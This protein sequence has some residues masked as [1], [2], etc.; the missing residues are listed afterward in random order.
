MNISNSSGFRVVGSTSNNVGRDQINQVISITTQSVDLRGTVA[1]VIN[2]PTNSEDEEYDEFET[3]KRGDMLIV[4]TIL[5]EKFREWEWD[6]TLFDMKKA[7]DVERRV[8]IARIQ[9]KPAST[10]IVM[11]YRGQGSSAVKFLIFSRYNYT[12]SNVSVAQAWKRDFLK[13]SQEIDETRLQLFGIN[14]SSIPS[15]I[16]YDAG[17]MPVRHFIRESEFWG[18]LFLEF[19]K[20]V[21]LRES[22]V[23]LDP[24]LNCW[25]DTRTAMLCND[26]TRAHT[27]HIFGEL[28]FQ[29]NLDP[30]ILVPSG[31]DMLKQDTAIRFF[32]KQGF[33]FDRAIVQY[34]YAIRN[35]DTIEC[36]C[37]IGSEWW[38]PPTCLFGPLR[39]DAIYTRSGV[40]IAR[41]PYTCESDIGLWKAPVRSQT[42]IHDTRLTR[43]VLDPPKWGV[44]TVSFEPSQSYKK[45]FQE[46]WLA[47]APRVFNATSTN[48]EDY[49]MIFSEWSVEFQSPYNFNPLAMK[50]ERIIYLFMH[51]LPY[52]LTEQSLLSWIDSGR[53][54]FWSFDPVGSSEIPRHEW[55]HLGIPKLIPAVKLPRHEPAKWPPSVYDAIRDWQVA[56]GL[57]PNT[58]DFARSLGYPE[59]EILVDEPN[60]SKT[61]T[62][63]W[64]SIARSIW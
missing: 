44:F 33:Y 17:L 24:V 10:F 39:F 15:L 62:T 56:R 47:Q 18:G 61:Q 53:T 14:R 11:S 9:N 29:P 16:F 36:E 12:S 45:A 51:P 38:H 8:H 13:T 3:V 4:K 50:R 7:I 25:I 41:L 58:A 42:R 2:R 26:P 64:Q 60:K 31:M 22:G 43:M 40:E 1:T 48:P 57:D 34:A 55:E 54:H 21:R 6:P 30:K 63:F 59:L 27:M 37:G 35:R 46:A 23:H 5:S 52:P 28:D 20:C 49:P 32:G 19:Q